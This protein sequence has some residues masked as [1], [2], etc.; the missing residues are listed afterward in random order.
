MYSHTNQKIDEIRR[1][2]D[3]I[4]Q[5]GNYYCTQEIGRELSNIR[6]GLD[7]MRL[8]NNISSTSKFKGSPGLNTYTS[9]PPDLDRVSNHLSHLKH[10]MDIENLQGKQENQLRERHH[11]AVQNLRGI[12][13]DLDPHT[14]QAADRIRQFG[15]HIGVTDS[16]T[17]YRNNL[18]RGSREPF[19]M[20]TAWA[21]KNCNTGYMGALNAARKFH[22]DRE[23]Q[24]AMMRPKTAPSL[25]GSKIQYGFNAQPKF[26]YRGY[27]TIDSIYPRSNTFHQTSGP[28]VSWKLNETKAENSLNKFPRESP[29]Q[30]MTTTDPRGMQSMSVQEQAGI[31]TRFPGPTEYSTKFERPPMDIPTSAFNINPTPNFHLH[32]R[33]LG[34]ET[35]DACN[36]EYQ[37]R[38][39]WPDSNKIVRMPWLRK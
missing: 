29:Y 35:Y 8:D 30:T 17:G 32:G 13:Q 39:E 22:E 38:Y 27:Q 16:Y 15:D 31:N 18:S 9:G 12:Q 1:D 33:P 34:T 7:H 6:N 36:T 37:V 21:D 28:A 24:S 10:V 4:A 19:Q 3:N 26:D 20:R 23:R 11:Y 25:L 5:S 14:Y 2:I